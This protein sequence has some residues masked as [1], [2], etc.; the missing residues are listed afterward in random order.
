MITYLPA[1][2]NRKTELC[3]KDHISA[4]PLKNH[5]HLQM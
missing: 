1:S 4:I 5:F 2:S 3:L